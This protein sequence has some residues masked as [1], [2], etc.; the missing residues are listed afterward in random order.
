MQRRRKLKQNSTQ[1]R[2]ERFYQVQV[3]VELPFAIAQFAVVGNGTVRFERKEE[4][5]RRLV[6]PVFCRLQ[7][8][9]MVE[10]AIQFDRRELSA[11][12]FEK[13]A[14]WKI[15]RVQNSAPVLIV[16]AR[17]TYPYTLSH[18]DFTASYAVSIIILISSSLITYGGMKYTTLPS[19]RT[20]TPR[21]RQK[22]KIFKFTRSDGT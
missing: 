16:K 6:E 22:S 8:R 17:S 21:L 1:L 9:K 5:F 7:S 20:N 19:G 13:T 10:G 18:S 11:V 14:F 3:T 4:I 15:L 12:K 2:L